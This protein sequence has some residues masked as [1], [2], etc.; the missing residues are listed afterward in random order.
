M[1]LY[2]YNDSLQDENAENVL[3]NADVCDH[4]IMK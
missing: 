1:L 3:N 2:T 4:V